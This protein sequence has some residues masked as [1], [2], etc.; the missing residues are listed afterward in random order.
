[1]ADNAAQQAEESR[2]DSERAFGRRDGADNRRAR[3]RV[4]ALLDEGS[5][6]EVGLLAR[7]R[8]HGRGE[9]S[10]ADALIAGYGT[11]NGHRVGVISLDGAVLAGSGGHAGSA[12]QQR[13]I[14]EASRCGFPV[15]SFGEG[16]GGRI[17]DMMGS[18]LGYA[19]AIGS[20]AL[21][22]H[23]ARRDRGFTL[24]ACCMGEMYGD[25]SFKLGLA[26]FPLMVRTASLAVSG[27]PVIQAALGETVTGAELGGPD[28]HESNGQ[29]A[30]VGDTEDDVIDTVRRLLDYTLVPEKPTV[31][32]IDRETPEIGTILPAAENRAYDV[33]KVIRSLVDADCDPL[34]LWPKFGPTAVA[35]LARIDGRTVAL[36]ANQPMIRGG[37]FD[38]DSARKASKLLT[39]CESMGI[40]MVYLHDVPGFIVGKHAEREGLLGFAME[41]L[42]DLSS[43]TIPKVS[44]VLRKS[45]GLAYFAMAG[46]GWGADYIAALPSA[47][48]AFMGAEPGV[49]LVYAKKLARTESD[50]ERETMLEQLTGEWRERA[51]PWEAAELASVDDII[52]PSEVRRTVARALHALSRDRGAKA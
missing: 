30:F 31:D 28:V 29:V 26:D 49:N 21:L 40:P 51:E 18:S 16:G 14:N 20:T 47:R 38:V 41:Y 48:I 6:V 42:R 10:P 25:P 13:I 44:V 5:F 34:Y 19:G 23:I 15:I 35:C 36:F 1:M 50:E 11:V 46:P 7:D 52:E 9:K 12:K 37:V 17:P 8:S 43:S 27:P 2:L 24:I 22:P 39:R 3:D 45:F 4:E 33:K 32:P